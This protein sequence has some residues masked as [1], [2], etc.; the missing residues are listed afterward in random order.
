MPGTGDVRQTIK[1]E[2]NGALTVGVKDRQQL[3]GPG[4][5][6]DVHAVVGTA[7]TGGP[8]TFQVRVEGTVAATVSIPAGTTEIDASVST[9]VAFT[10]GQTLDINVTAVGPT[11]AGSD[12]DVT[13]EY[14]NR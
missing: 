7:P 11:V 12:L 9:P 13:V 8:V 4:D 10:E 14:V 2:A 5:I 3:A 6:V 1:L